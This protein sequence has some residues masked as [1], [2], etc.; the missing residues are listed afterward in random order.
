MRFEN[1]IYHEPGIYFGMPEDEYHAD[2]SI[3]STDLL[4]LL[5]SPVD[6]YW[7]SRANPH[8]RPDRD[9]P[10][11]L[12]GKAIHKCVLEGREAFDK[13]Y[14]CKGPPPRE[15]AL[16]TQDDLRKRC[17]FLGLAKSGTKPQL[18]ERIR[19][20]DKTCIIHDEDVEAYKA[21]VEGK[22]LLDEQDYAEILMAAQ[23]IRSNPHLKSAFTD[24][25]P[26]VSMFWD[27]GGVPFRARFD[28]LKLKAIVDLK[29]TRNVMNMPWDQAVTNFLARGNYYIQATHYMQARQLLPKFLKEGRVFGDHDQKWL[30]K[31]AKTPESSFIWVVYQAEGAPLT[32]P[33]MFTDEEP[34]YARA[35]GE[36]ADAMEKY[37]EGFAR[38]GQ[39]QWVEESK[40]QRYSNLPWPMWRAGATA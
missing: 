4:R 26:E 2:W 16:I 5:V 27:V 13:L 36:I 22:V 21:Q 35:I 25:Y 11:M 20:I 40:I 30:A 6:Y 15:G 3:G 10:A 12:Y 32:Y 14:A 24:G 31:A 39:S 17:E 34:D 29:S 28:Y 9:T 23:N 18:I 33:V 19:Q 8:R 38:F 37:K 1:G 7:F